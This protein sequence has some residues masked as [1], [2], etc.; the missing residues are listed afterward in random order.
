[1]A[2]AKPRPSI[3]RELKDNI[4][5]GVARPP[6]DVRSTALAILAALGMVFFIKWASPVLIPIVTAIVLSYA[7]TPIVRW[8]DRRLKLPKVVGAAVTLG[9]I[10]LALGYGLTVLQPQA[11]DVLDIVPRA[12][13][14]L[15]GFYAGTPTTRPAPWTR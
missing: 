10:L 12:A 4:D 3:V 9:A 2:N 7:L 1:M 13:Q 5:T 6:T 14:S 11:L 15:R 8:I